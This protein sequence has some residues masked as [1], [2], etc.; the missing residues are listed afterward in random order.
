MAVD[1]GR[2]TLVDEGRRFDARRTFRSLL[3]SRDGRECNYR[4]YSQ[5][6]KYFRC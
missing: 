5:L 2:K 3:Q 1:A 4:D 6:L